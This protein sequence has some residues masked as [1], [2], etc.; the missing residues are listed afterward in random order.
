MFS[1]VADWRADR[2]ARS[3]RAYH[4]LEAEDPAAA[5]ALRQ[6]GTDE[7]PVVRL[8]LDRLAAGQRGAR[9]VLDDK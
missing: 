8:H 1:P 6:L 3:R 9:I 4:L 5:D 2:L 7:D